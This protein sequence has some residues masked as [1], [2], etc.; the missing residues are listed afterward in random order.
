MKILKLGELLTIVL[1]L[2]IFFSYKLTDI[3]PGITVDEAAFGYN[4]V[5]L[6]ETLRDE[7]N[8]LLPFFV[9]SIGG[10]DWRQPVTQYSTALAF[11][12]FGSSYYILR[13]VSVFFAVLSIILFVLLLLKIG[14]NIF[15]FFGG[16]VLTT[17]PMMMIQSH[18]GLDNIA[19]VPFVILWLMGLYYYQTTRRYKFLVLSA[20]TLGISFYSYKGM[21]LIVPIWSLLT[22]AY[23]FLLSYSPKKGILIQLFKTKAVLVFAAAIA[24]FALI[25]PYLQFLYPGALF[26]GA[27]PSFDSYQQFFLGYLSNLDLSFLFINGD[28]TPYHSVGKYGAF[29][30]SSLPLFLIGAYQSVKR[31]GFYLFVLIAFLTAPIFFGT[32]GSIH[33]SSRLLALMPLYAFIT[34]TGLWSVYNLKLKFRNFLLSSLIIILLL[35][36]AD[37]IWYYW[38]KYPSYYITQGAFQTRS[39]DSYYLLSQKAK[40]LNLKPIVQKDVF[41]S[42]GEAAKF[43]E[44][45]YFDQKLELWDTKDQLPKNA[46]VLSNQQELAG[47]ER[48]DLMIPAYN[49]L[50]PE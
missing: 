43:F 22:L 39:N 44:A 26:G 6:A 20:V 11:K 40:E 48:L 18:L 36:Y 31:R 1:F 25:T 50:V 21:R 41:E 17:I 32:V 24:P 27:R 23:L 10:N 45:A 46:I 14:G 29:L 49:I 16:L 7:N 2:W 12:L 13:S 8:R 3:P 5:L 34:A 33:R 19:P 28:A 15:A 30:L 47:F 42:D 4:G 37:F 9:L 38:N 35:N